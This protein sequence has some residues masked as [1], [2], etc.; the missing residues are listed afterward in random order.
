MTASFLEF[1]DV[2]RSD[3]PELTRTTR[4]RVARGSRTLEVINGSA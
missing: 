4:F 3:C 1:A 2:K